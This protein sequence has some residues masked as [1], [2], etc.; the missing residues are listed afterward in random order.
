[1]KHIGLQEEGDSFYAP[2]LMM[3]ENNSIEGL[4]LYTPDKN[5]CETFAEAVSLVK[6]AANEM[7]VGENTIIIVRIELVEEGT[8]RVLEIYRQEPPLCH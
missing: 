4:V 2:A 1:M 8:F 3:D 5:T 6:D 7:E